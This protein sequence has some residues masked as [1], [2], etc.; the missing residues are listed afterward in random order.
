MRNYHTSVPLSEMM[1]AE[2]QSSPYLSIV[3][4]DIPQWAER[5]VRHIETSVTQEVCKCEWTAHPDDVKIRPLHCR[6]CEHP[7]ER[8]QEVDGKIKCVP[9]TLERECAC[10]NYMPRRV[11][12]G[13]VHPHCPVHTPVGRIMGFFEYV[14]SQ[15]DD[16]P[17]LTP[18]Q[19]AMAPNGGQGSIPPS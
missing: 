3:K 8:H 19:K 2:T 10:I 5:Y 6:D 9:H 17:E 14:F 7:R 15:K 1:D 16:M 4:R 11:K 12:M 13:D 18:E